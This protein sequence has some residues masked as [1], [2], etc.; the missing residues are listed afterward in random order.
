MSPP[1]EAKLSKAEKTTHTSVDTICFS[2]KEA[3][4]WE[5]PADIQRGVK[6]NKK[7]MELAMQIKNDGGVIPGIITLGVLDKKTYLIDGLQRREAF[8]IS[9]H[10]YGYA[11][12]RTCYFKTRAEMGEEFV[13]LNSQLVKMT[14]DDIL[15]GLEC[16]VP[17]LRQIRQAC[18]FVAYGRVRSGGPQGHAT[19]L[20]M[21]TTLRCWAGSRKE[22]PHSQ[23]SA[24]DLARELQEDETR[25]LI[26]YLTLTAA[27]W[28]R[29]EQYYRMWSAVNLMISM[30]LYRRTVTDPPQTGYSR[31]IKLTPELFKKCLMSLSADRGYLDWLVGRNVGERDRA[32]CYNRMKAIFAGRIHEETG[33]RE[34]LPQPEWAH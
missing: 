29:D 32:P 19:M 5:V 25:K 9:E 6:V 27:A 23:G 30:W 8:F 18:P 16:A 21:S 2:V 34:K 31:S 11:D 10:L 22:M 17:F 13:R 28:G 1:S 3:H 12:V 7:V 26:S 4:E 24:L 15:R 33:K 14:P 20:S